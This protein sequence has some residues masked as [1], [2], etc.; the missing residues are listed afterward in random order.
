[1]FLDE[2]TRQWEGVDGERPV[3]AGRRTAA[4]LATLERVDAG[5]LVVADM[6]ARAADEHALEECAAILSGR[7]DAVLL[8]DAPD[9]RVQY[10]PSL[11]AMLLARQGIAVWSGVNCRDRNR[12]ALEGEVAGLA[13]AGVA[14]V[15]CVTGDH[16]SIGHRPDAMPVF[17][18]DGVELAAVARG[19]GHLV[20]V[21]EAPAA[22]PVGDRVARLRVKEDAGADVCFIDHCG[23]TAPVRRFVRAARDAGSELRFIACVPAVFDVESASELDSFPGLVLPAGF[24]QRI[25]GAR[26]PR[27]AGIDSAIALAE[28]LLE[29]DGVDGVDLS[30]GSGPGGELAY[31]EAVAEVA[32]GITGVAA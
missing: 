23:G 21:A 14:A 6:P 27:R 28:E 2:T 18:L 24:M 26:D 15:H 5:R 9:A 8:G 4:A 29:V 17:D 32:D 30:G 22:P 13:V 25:A 7:V 19:A 10:P 3:A 1:M 11:R 20:S 16:T 12:V 31:A